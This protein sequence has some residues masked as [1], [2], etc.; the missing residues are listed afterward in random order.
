VNQA[1]DLAKEVFEI[2]RFTSALASSHRPGAYSISGMPVGTETIK[3]ILALLNFAETL[4]KKLLSLIT[5]LT[6]Q[7]KLLATTDDAAVKPFLGD[8]ITPGYYSA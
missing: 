7:D 4:G 6:E 8:P 5:Q 3:N 2:A 1:K